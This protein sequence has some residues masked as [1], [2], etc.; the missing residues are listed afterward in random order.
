MT[1]IIEADD[2]N[3]VTNCTVV[4]AYVYEDTPEYGWNLYK[5]LRSNEKFT[6]VTYADAI[7]YLD[8]QDMEGKLTVGRH[9]FYDDVD[10][11]NLPYRR[12][13][14]IISM[15]GTIY[16][17]VINSDGEINTCTKDSLYPIDKVTD[18]VNLEN[19]KEEIDGEEVCN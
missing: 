5:Q 6:G 19:L 13:G 11:A 18:T 14:I 1:Y 17:N 10:E 16:C 3:L 9:V 4:K 12:K 7:A 15:K 8:Q 2:I